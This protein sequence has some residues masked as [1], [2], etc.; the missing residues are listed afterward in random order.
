M[1]IYIY[2]K[3]YVYIY[4]YMFLYIYISVYMATYFTG[5]VWAVKEC[6]T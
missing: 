1:N 5:T 4:I 6:C 2:G 3:K